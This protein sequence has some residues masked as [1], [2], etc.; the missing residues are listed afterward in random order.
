MFQQFF[1]LLGPGRPLGG[2]P[3]WDRGALIQFGWVQLGVFQ[4]LAL[5]LRR[6]ARIGYCSSNKMFT[7]GQKF[8]PTIHVSLEVWSISELK[9]VCTDF[10]FISNGTNWMQ[11]RP[12]WASKRLIWIG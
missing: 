1:S 12:E 8:L 4:R 2:G 7:V 10:W 5:R 11:K 6:S 3:R 9:S